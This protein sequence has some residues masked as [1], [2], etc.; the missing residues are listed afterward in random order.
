MP[1]SDPKALIPRPNRWTVIIIAGV[2]L[3]GC[4]VAAV[5]KFIE[6]VVMVTGDEETASAGAFTVTPVV[7]YLLASLG[8]LCL[9]CWATL[10]GMFR[11][12]EEPKMTMLELEEQLER[13]DPAGD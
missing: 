1:D 5:A 2:I 11:D 13:R 8:F 3:V 9:F 6:L 4:G 7:N 12:V 10:G